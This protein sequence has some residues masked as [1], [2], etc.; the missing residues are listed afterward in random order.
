MELL[1]THTGSYDAVIVGGRVAGAATGMLLA[2]AGHRVAIVDRAAFP[3]DTLSTHAIARTGV[4]QL[5]RWGLLEAVLASGAPAVTDVVFH[6]AGERVERTIKDRYG[7]DFL[8]APR[9]FVLDELL[10][11]A[12]RDAG[13]DVLTEARVTD[14]VFD[15]R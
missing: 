9:R 11:R 14:V 6:H 2:R 13:A 15:G 10:L 5:H 8:V 12:A 4:V 3:S 1:S 7:V